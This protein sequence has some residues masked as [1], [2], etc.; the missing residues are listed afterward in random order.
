M[1]YTDALIK[2]YKAKQEGKI[3]TIKPEYKTKGVPKDYTHSWWYEG[4]W[5]E[6][7]T[8]PG[9]WKIKFTASKN[10]PARTH[11]FVSD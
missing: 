2:K 9:T 7:K 11:Y 6:T 3:K 1:N 8:G 5:D 4:T 10:R